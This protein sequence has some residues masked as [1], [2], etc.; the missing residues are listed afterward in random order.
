MKETR[1]IFAA[2]PENIWQYRQNHPKLVLEDCM[3]HGFTKEQ[4][5]VVKQSM[6]V[7]GVNKWLKVRRDI[8]AYKKRLDKLIA[9]SDRLAK[10][11]KEV[12]TKYYCYPGDRN[13]PIYLQ[14]LIQYQTNKKIRLRLIAIR[15]DLKALCMTD[16][17]Q[18]WGG[19]KMGDMNG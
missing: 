17:W 19:K 18:D 8:I 10:H 7:R 5:E 6:L 2:T 15:K 3:R 11:A 12:M 16:R 13:Y 9:V 14:A 1:D 4:I